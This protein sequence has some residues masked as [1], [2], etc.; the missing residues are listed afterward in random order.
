[1]KE[2]LMKKI[3]KHVLGSMCLLV[4]LSAMANYPDRHIE[5]VV[6]F[7]VGGTSDLMGRAIANSLEKILKQ[8]IIVVNRPGAGGTIG[9]NH[10]ARA[11]PDGYTLV[12]SSVSGM[13][14]GPAC[15]PNI[16][17]DS[18]KDFIQV[19]TFSQVPN[20]VAVHESFP[21]K[22]FRGFIQ[23][24]KKNPNK[25]NYGAQ[26]CTH[27]QMI[28]EQI[29]IGSGVEFNFIPYKT[30][31]QVVVDTLN[32]QVQILFETVPTSWQHIQLGR[33]RPMAVAW[34]TRLPEL[35][36]VPT[37]LE[38]GLEDANIT[39]W[40]GI[41][42]PSGTPPEIVKK[43]NLAIKEAIKD[44][45]FLEKMKSQQAMPDYSTPEEM[46]KMLQRE[47]AKHKRA[48]ATGRIRTN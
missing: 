48:I 34:H 6:A 18:V 31:P 38:L 43:L 33:V 36:N 2:N 9:V 12:V 27:L 26:Y 25:Y 39:A 13:A 15:V 1:L 41:A 5:L 30:G 40:Y 10:V 22:D 37:L 19:S 4:S 35:P 45:E 14:V 16:P 20:L 21:A 24:L 17:Y 46:K 7:G 11:K 47:V 8:P 42:V 23:E 3:I 44:P 32:N 29:K 28:A